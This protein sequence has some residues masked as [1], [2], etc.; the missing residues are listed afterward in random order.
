MA[1]DEVA[2]NDDGHREVS[3]TK[4]RDEMKPSDDDWTFGLRHPLDLAHMVDVAENL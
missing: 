3:I 1:L 4:W 2:A